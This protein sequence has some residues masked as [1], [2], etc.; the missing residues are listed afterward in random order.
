MEIIT[1]DSKYDI[2]KIAARKAVALLNRAIEEKG[3]ANIIIATGASQ[4]KFLD[5][6]K[7]EGKEE[8][9]DWTK[10]SVFHLDEYIGISEDHPASFRKYLKEHFLNIVGPVEEVHFVV[11]DS[12][13]PSEECKRIGSIIADKEIDIAFVGIGENGHLAFND[14]PADFTIKAPYLVVDLDEQCRM[15]QVNEGCF[16][17]LKD[18]PEKAI[19][20]SVRQIMKSKNIICSVPDLRKAEAVKNCLEKE[21]SDQYPASILR[22]HPSCFVYLD[23][24]SSSLLQRENTNNR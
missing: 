6:L 12:K 2:A 21:I 7:N 23:K 22:E 16:P 17:D 8:S 24:D 11:G 20:M 13:N 3:R 14:P 10:V 5:S 18:V 4:D 1:R 15:Q 9:V 19:S